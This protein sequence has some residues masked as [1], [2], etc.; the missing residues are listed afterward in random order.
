V[1][2][3]QIIA[4][5]WLAL[6]CSLAP[7]S[8]EKRV[9]LVVGN[10]KYTGIP[11]LRNPANDARLIAD[12]L[13]GLG[14]TLTGGGP[15][16]D[17]D[18]A[19]LD[20]AVQDFGTQVQSAEVALFYYAGHGVQ[21]RGA[22]YL[23]PVD[24]NVTREADAEFQMLNVN[25][26]LDQIDPA[27]RPG[28]RLNV[29]ILDACRNNPFGGRGLPRTADRGLGVMQAPGG[30]L[31]SFATQPGAV[32]QDGDGDHSPFTAALA[33]V[34][35]R[36][37]LGL[38]DTFNEI[39][40]IVKRTTSVQQPWVSSSPIAGQFY[41]GGPPA[42]TPPA[43]R[44]P[45][46]PAGA[47]VA[48][49]VTPDTLVVPPRS[50]G[51]LTAAQDRALKPKDS[52]KECSD[53]PEMVVVP[54]GSFTM[55][56]PPGEKGRYHDESPQHVV[57]IGRPIAVGK[58]HVTVDQYAAFVAETQHV[59]R[60]GCSWR[61]PGFA[62][63][64]SHPVVCVDWGDANAYANWLAKK[65]GR[66]YHLLSEAEFEYA[67]RGR[68][69]SG[70]YPRFSFGDDEEDLCRY[71]NFADREYGA[72]DAP[73]ND[74]YDR[75][76][77]AGHYMPN[78]F[79]LYDMSGNAWQWTADCDHDNY[80][81]APADGTA[82]TTGGAC[83]GGRVVRGGSWYY[84]PRYLRAANRYRLSGPYDDVGFRLARSLTP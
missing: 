27:D 2:F 69:A 30:T 48:M 14:F 47:A 74:G 63:E 4:M 53:C 17:L 35:R 33:E 26:V 25:R 44:P 10:S 11:P 70:A 28:G 55:G 21:I 9:A 84:S 54:A 66:P 12:T 38:F 42:A 16:I 60:G 31:I 61:S 29:V 18:K 73:C 45:V 76:S 59:S 46:S 80:I 41:F 22:N 78:D 52:F 75:T 39:G 7:A 67:A 64:G 40:L 51:P 83:D 68:T 36:P 58:F 56:S 57:T 79:G 81:G 82:W 13:R 5:T 19:G 43:G 15:Q 49:T 34:I 37:G 72:K 65:T 50:G 6:A 71:G 23:V 24:A 1:R 32:A 20:R 3:L 8:A 62:Q 77:P